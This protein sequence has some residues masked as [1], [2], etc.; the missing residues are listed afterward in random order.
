MVMI[1]GNCR[2]SPN[3]FAPCVAAASQ[4]RQNLPLYCTAVVRPPQ[5]VRDSLVASLHG[6]LLTSFFACSFLL[7]MVL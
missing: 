6:R 5:V 3:T 2:D 1:H 4:S 7:Q